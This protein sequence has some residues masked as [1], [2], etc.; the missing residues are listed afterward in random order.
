M[1]HRQRSTLTYAFVGCVGVE[2]DD[3]D[4]VE[5]GADE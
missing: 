5:A 3:Q 2:D 1:L 4:E